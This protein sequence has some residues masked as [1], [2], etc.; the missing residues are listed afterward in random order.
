MTLSMHQLLYKRKEQG[1]L[2]G[3]PSSEL[4]IDFSSNDYLGLARSATLSSTIIQEWK[5]HQ[6][7]LTKI[8]STGSRLLTGN[9]SYIQELE[10]QIAA[11]HGYEAGLLFNC[12]Y[13]ANL[14]LLSTIATDQDIIFFDFAA[15]AS[16]KD[17]IRLSQA[18]AFPFKHNDL[19][20]L[21]SRLQ[22]CSGKGN[23][24]ICIESLYS[25]DGSQAPLS[26]MVQLAE[27]FEAH[28]IV[29]EAHAVGVIGPQGKGLVAKEG[30]TRHVFAQVVTFGKA[31][32]VQGAIVLGSHLL[33]ET[34]INFAHPFIYTTALPFFSLAAI[35]CSYK[36]LP[37]LE[38]ER[39]QVQKLITAF[40]KA[41]PS[42]A[43]RSH[44]QSILCPGN[45]AAKQKSKSLLK[46]GFDVRPLLSPTVRK[47]KEILRICLHA[48]NTEKE[49]SDLMEK[50][51][52]Y[53]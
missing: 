50:V 41:Y 18:Q 29:D 21:K 42:A 40:C 30:L 45:A 17:G 5:T 36:R 2:R 13:M 27:E 44:I 48:F 32:G 33:K 6:G 47:G 43:S 31:L 9:S 53:A 23:R 3:L 39:E 20:H 12:G 11:F 22:N 38:Q 52:Q 37:F 14:G 8:G 34:L 25:T 19:S 24:F 7:C 15:H 1:N 35:Y 49:L 46:E 26:E 10:N 51:R 28:L 16:T 4:L